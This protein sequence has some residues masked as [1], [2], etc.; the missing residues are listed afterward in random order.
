MLNIVYLL[1]VLKIKICDLM[2]ID[3]AP[4]KTRIWRKITLSL[5]SIAKLS[6]TIV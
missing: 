4:S 6:K 3:I 1:L 2:P 5:K